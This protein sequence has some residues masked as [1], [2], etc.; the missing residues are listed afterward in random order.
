VQET[1]QEHLVGFLL[2]AYKKTGFGFKQTSQSDLRNV[3]ITDGN[4]EFVHNL[5]ECQ[6]FKVLISTT[7]CEFKWNV[8]VWACQKCVP[9]LP[10]THWYRKVFP[11]W[12]GHWVTKGTPS[13]Y[14]LPLCQIPCQW[15]VTSIPSIP[16]RTSMTTLSPSQTCNTYRSAKNEI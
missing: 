16:F 1:T 11:C 5:D 6:A 2:Y 9:A 10:A 4:W 14:W 8:P 13:E 3:Y 12:I 7:F 15:M